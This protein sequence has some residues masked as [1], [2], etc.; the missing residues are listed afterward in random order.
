MYRLRNRFFRFLLR[1][2][3]MGESRVAHLY[4]TLQY[5]FWNSVMMQNEFVRLHSP[6]NRIIKRNEVTAGEAKRQAMW[7]ICKLF[8]TM[9]KWHTIV[10]LPFKCTGRWIKLHFAVSIFPWSWRPKQWR[11]VLAMMECMHHIW[12]RIRLP[13]CLLSV[14]AA[15]KFIFFLCEE[16][17]VIFSFARIVL[18]PLRRDWRRSSP[19]NKTALLRFCNFIYFSENIW[20]LR[21]ALRCILILI[22]ILYTQR[23]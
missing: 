13:L 10:Y 9:H 15:A 3:S 8:S 6:P 7:T 4:N 20:C 14:C 18:V 12:A 1:N 22:L 16:S 21:F 11:Q 17:A 19:K 5:N 2:S 23:G